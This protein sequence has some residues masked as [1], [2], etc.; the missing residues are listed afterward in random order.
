MEELDIKQLWSSYDAKLERSLALNLKVIK[1]LQTQKAEHKLRSF[2]RNQVTGVILGV[3]WIAFLV[4][5]LV[6]TLHNMYFVIS[7][8]F[9]IL[10]NVF[11]TAAYIRHLV[12][13]AQVNI[14]DS[15]TES[16][17]KITEIQSSFTNV[18]RILVLQAPFYCT[19]WYNNDLVANAGIG[20][21]LIQVVIVSFFTF[22]SIF[23]FKKLTYKNRHIKWVKAALESFG[24]KTLTKAMEFLN[25]IEEYKT[26]RS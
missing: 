11:A 19:F 3:I 26:E 1:E 5:L 7:V 15:V 13:L 12:M 16:Q 4:F 8:G 2:R 6:N 20:F 17:R 10:F 9:I 25:E 23:L 22:I 24:G 21:W 14:D 18:G